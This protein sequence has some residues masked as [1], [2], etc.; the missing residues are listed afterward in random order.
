MPQWPG[1]L[2][3]PVRFPP[4][5]LAVASATFPSFTYAS[6]QLWARG[7]APHLSLNLL[8]LFPRPG[9]GS[10]A[11][12]L[13]WAV[14]TDFFDTLQSAGRHLAFKEKRFWI[15]LE[16]ESVASAAPRKKISDVLLQCL[17]PKQRLYLR[18]CLVDAD[19]FM[20][21]RA[22]LETDFLDLLLQSETTE[23]RSID[24]F[25]CSAEAARWMR[26]VEHHAVCRTCPGEDLT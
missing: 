20:T 13:T 8:L 11:A 10:S 21:L 25:A 16:R 22:T 7:T 23:W 6:A 19:E 9:L 26:S 15:I 18:G 3:L 24:A 2:P 14:R 17:I 5:A 12:V 1:R 4:P